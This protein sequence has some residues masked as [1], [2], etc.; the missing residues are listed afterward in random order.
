YRSDATGREVRYHYTWEDQSNG[1]YSFLGHIFNHY[2][3][4]TEW[5]GTRPGAATLSNADVY[6]IVD[7]DTEKETASPNVLEKPEI[8]A[9]EEWVRQG[10]VLVLLGNDAGNAE[11][12]HFN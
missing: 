9:I 6:V 5:L 10:G 2:G 8:D 3:A 11:F 7:P 4:K 1:G 12:T